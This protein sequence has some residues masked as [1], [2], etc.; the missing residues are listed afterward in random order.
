MLVL[1]AIKRVLL[2]ISGY[3][4][5]PNVNAQATDDVTVGVKLFR[6]A[7]MD[8]EPN[9]NLIYLTLLKPTE[10]GSS[11]QDV[12][13][14]SKWLNYSC[15]LKSGDSDRYITVAIGSGT[16]PDGLKL[17]VTASSYTGSGGGTT[18]TAAGTITLSATAQ[19]LISGIRGAYTGTGA[20]N[21]HQLTYKLEI[22]DYSKL[23]FDNS[24]T[25]QIDFTIV[26]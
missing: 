14:N 9:N 23:D 5:A 16:V 21:G 8:I 22:T 7:I 12:T 10:A 26:D 2:I 11:A 13:N 17:T 18:G 20:N 4:F 15:C 24:T 1:D 25:I 19:T 6:V 3:V